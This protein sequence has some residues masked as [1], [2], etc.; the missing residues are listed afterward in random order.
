M[1]ENTSNE[2]KQVEFDRYW[3]L[4][5]LVNGKKAYR[6]RVAGGLPRRQRL[7]RLTWRRA[8]EAEA[9]ARKVVARWNQIHQG[10]P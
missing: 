7:L 8:A 10:Q 3:K 9:Y 6:D 1:I 4:P 2:I 5:F